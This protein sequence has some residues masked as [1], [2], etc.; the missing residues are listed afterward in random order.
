M[1]GRVSPDPIENHGAADLAAQTG[2]HVK[3]SPMK[4]LVEKAYSKIPPSNLAVLD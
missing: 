4:G 2:E 3:S 1:V